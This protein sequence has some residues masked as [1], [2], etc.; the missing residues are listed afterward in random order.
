MGFLDDVFMFRLIR[1]HTSQAKTNELPDRLA[2]T[3]N[4]PVETNQWKTSIVARLFIFHCCFFLLLSL[5]RDR[6]G[7][8]NMQ[9]CVGNDTFHKLRF[10]W[11][12]CARLRVTSGLF[13]DCPSS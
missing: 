4:E 13:E 6:L 11:A 8:E 7:T 9:L 5:I 3:R 1:T 12:V 2:H 10:H